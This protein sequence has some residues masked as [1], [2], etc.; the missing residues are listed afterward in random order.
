[1]KSQPGQ[2]LADRYVKI[3]LHHISRIHY[4]PTSTSAGSNG[5]PPG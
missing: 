3:D 5:P 2:E 4:L 1:V